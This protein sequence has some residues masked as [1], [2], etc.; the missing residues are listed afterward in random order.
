M[1]AAIRQPFPFVEAIMAGDS[2]T[3]EAVFEDGVFRPVQ[4]LTLA[5]RQRV[6]L[7]VQLSRPAAWPADVAAIY[8]ELAEEDRRLA[9]AMLPAVRETW[10]AGEGSP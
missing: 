8:Q 1:R 5:P 9:E 3:V 10:P 6:T 7:V 4:P 2:I